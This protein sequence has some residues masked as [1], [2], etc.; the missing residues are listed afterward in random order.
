VSIPL[1]VSQMPA[2]PGPGDHGPMFAE[3]KSWSPSS[4]TWSMVL[5]KPSGAPWSYRVQ[6]NY[7]QQPSGLTTVWQAP[8]QT[9]WHT[10]SL[11]LHLATGSAGHAYGVYFDGVQQ[12]I[13][14]SLTFPTLNSN[15]TSEP[16]DI[17]AYGN[18][19]QGSYTFEHGAP[20]IQFNDTNQPPRPTW[21][22]TGTP[23]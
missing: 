23:G 1:N 2:N 4:P 19:A 11:C 6:F 9:G 12:P 8:V 14:N 10:L 5:G 21:N 18:S 13:T 16:L 7:T 20:L 22:W 17:D 15:F 3:E